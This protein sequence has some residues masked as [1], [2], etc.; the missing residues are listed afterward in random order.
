MKKYRIVNL[1]N[2]SYGIQKRRWLLWWQTLPV[3]TDYLNGAYY[4]IARLSQ[5]DREQQE[6]KKGLKV[7]SVHKYNKVEIEQPIQY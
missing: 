7:V 3:T 1:A 6:I 2:G 5:K 4:E